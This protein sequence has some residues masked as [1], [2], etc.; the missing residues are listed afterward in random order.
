MNTMSINHWI[1]I[2]DKAGFKIID[3]EF[4]DI[5]RIVPIDF[6]NEE[7]IKSEIDC[8][9]SKNTSAYKNKNEMS[10]NRPNGKYH[11]KPNGFKSATHSHK[12][13]WEKIIELNTA[14]YYFVFEVR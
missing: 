1:D 8:A 3:L 10:I 5:E 14:D 13:I 6:N 9:C 4:N 2:F 11:K 12:K 7:L